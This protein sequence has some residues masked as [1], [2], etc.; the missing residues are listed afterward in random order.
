MVTAS[1]P[2]GTG[3]GRDCVLPEAVKGH[4]V[5][6]GGS[7]TRCHGRGNRRLGSRRLREGCGAFLDKSRHGP[8]RLG[9]R[10]SRIP[11]VGP[12]TCL[13]LRDREPL[14]VLTAQPP[15]AASPGCRWPLGGGRSVPRGWQ[16]G[17]HSWVPPC[18]LRVRP[19][20]MDHGARA[21]RQGLTKAP[22]CCG[23]MLGER[24]LCGGPGPQAGCRGER[25]GLPGAR[26]GPPTPVV[27]PRPLRLL[28]SCVP[29]PR[30]ALYG[31]LSRLCPTTTQPGGNSAPIKQIRN[32]DSERPGRPQVPQV[33]KQGLDPAQAHLTPSP[34]DALAQ[35][36]TPLIKCNK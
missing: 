35:A 8:R 30:R 2:A 33:V 15:R 4:V 31:T 32:R 3:S 6:C 23:Q 16:D 12:G 20:G 36:H 29:S 34:P 1:P 28:H 24:P 13:V 17:P 11:D 9:S 25:R 14:P 19:Q 7:L 27:P 18:T 26:D 10:P 21:L 22:V 5:W